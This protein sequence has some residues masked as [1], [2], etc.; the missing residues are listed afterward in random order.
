MI[1]LRRFIRD[2]L[3]VDVVEYM[4][5]LAFLT[6]G[7]VLMFMSSGQTISGIWSTVHSRLVEANAAVGYQGYP[8]KK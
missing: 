7:S 2:D 6:V 8:L 3:G 5:L 1:M 4:L